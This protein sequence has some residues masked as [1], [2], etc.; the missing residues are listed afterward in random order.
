MSSTYQPD[1]M[2][3]YY[4]GDDAVNNA[5]LNGRRTLDLRYTVNWSAN[6]PAY[7]TWR[8][9]PENWKLVTAS[10]DLVNRNFSHELYHSADPKVFGLAKLYFNNNKLIQVQ[11]AFHTDE[12]ARAFRELIAPSLQEEPQHPTKPRITFWFDTARGPNSM[13]KA[14]EVPMEEKILYNYSSSIRPELESLVNLDPAKALGG[15]LILMYGIPGTGKTY[16]I[17]YLMHK[18]RKWCTYQYIT[19]PENF[20]QNPSYLF[21][22]VGF[23]DDDDDHPANA[24]THL[25]ILED[26]GEFI[27]SD[28]SSEFVHKSL[29]KLLNVTD[30]LLGQGLKLLVLIT[31]NRKTDSLD[32]AVLRAGRCLSQV[33]FPRLQAYEAREW[34]E[35]NGLL[36]PKLSEPEYLLADLYNLEA[37]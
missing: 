2:T 18:W 31:T 26:S 12:A 11:S 25:V 14:I 20:F 33:E 7:L 8:P 10:Y 9:E 4:S 5:F 35:R 3:Q 13:T 21:E 24:K 30:G 32:S 37:K 1:V 16:F 36:V 17:R 23:D 28:S 19:D 15:K 27:E 6:G 34:Y 22:V 29:N